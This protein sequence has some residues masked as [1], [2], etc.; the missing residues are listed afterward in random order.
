MESNVI[1][2]LDDRTATVLMNLVHDD[3]NEFE[4]IMRRAMRRNRRAGAQVEVAN[5][6]VDPTR[7]GNVLAFDT[8]LGTYVTYFGFDGDDNVAMA[9]L[10]FEVLD[11]QFTPFGLKY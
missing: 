5:L 3:D 11:Y 8:D 2:L 9:V 7:N 1:A 4:K 10:D 6:D